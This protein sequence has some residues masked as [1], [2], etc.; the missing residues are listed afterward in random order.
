V[1]VSVEQDQNSLKEKINEFIEAYN[2]VNEVLQKNEGLFSSSLLRNI[3]N[4]ILPQRKELQEL[5]ITLENDY[6]LTVNQK[7]LAD[8]MKNSLAKIRDVFAGYRLVSQ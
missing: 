4:C 5:G 7:K 2:Q 8:A 6:T 1:N 3:V